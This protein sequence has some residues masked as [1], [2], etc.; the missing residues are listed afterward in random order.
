MSK[1]QVIVN[2]YADD[3]LPN[4]Q[5]QYTQP[6]RVMLA[7]IVDDVAGVQRLV[8]ALSEPEVKTAAPRPPASN[9]EIAPR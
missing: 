4:S 6:E 3:K 9:D 2:E 5:N 7:A 8:N 1:F